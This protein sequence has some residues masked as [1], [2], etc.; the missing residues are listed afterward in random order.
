[1]SL[2]VQ[3]HPNL[4][5][6]VPEPH[7]KKAL[8]FPCVC[9]LGVLGIVMP[10]SAIHFHLLCTSAPNGPAQQSSSKNH[11]SPQC[12]SDYYQCSSAMSSLARSALETCSSDLLRNQEVLPA[13][14]MPLLNILCFFL[15]YLN[16]NCIYLLFC[17][18]VWL[19]G[20]HDMCV[21]V[22]VYV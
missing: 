8:S 14:H 5:I 19:C 12:S 9:G 22:F 16:Q 21:C 1:M 13:A 15:K 18:H 17:L 4:H 2:E 11:L 20:W 3:D 7:L 6:Q 10:K